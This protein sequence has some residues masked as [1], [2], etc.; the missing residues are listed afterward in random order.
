[1]RWPTP[2]RQNTSQSSGAIASWSPMA[3]A[4]STPRSRD[5][6][7]SLL[8]R[9][10]N[11]RSPAMQRVE[12]CSSPGL[13]RGDDRRGGPAAPHVARGP[14]AALERP[15]L[16]IEGVGIG[17]AARAL[18]AHHERAPLAGNELGRRGTVL[19]VGVPGEREG[20]RHV[21]SGRRHGLHV[22]DEARA[23]LLGLRQVRDD[24]CDGDVAP[25]PG[26]RQL[27]RE[28]RLRAPRRVV[29]ARERATQDQQP[30]PWD[31]C[32][33]EAERKRRGQ[34]AEQAGPLGQLRRRLQG[35]GAGHEGENEDTHPPTT[36]RA[37]IAR[38]G[39]RSVV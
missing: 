26:T 29:V 19:R 4:T 6:P 1:M 30:D 12:E 35:K 34:G 20:F 2:V 36:R 7:S 16:E 22:E 8:H 23:A 3:S 31:V 15:G 9:I 5:V 17:E 38:T 24:A 18:E 21:H 28:P 32:T 33:N 37:G 27:I 11:L 13:R 39:A 14:N 10:A 25:L